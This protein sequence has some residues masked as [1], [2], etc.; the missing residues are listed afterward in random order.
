[1]GEIF[2]AIGFEIPDEDSY[3]VLAEYAELNGERSLVYRGGSALHGRCWK[4]GRGLEVWSILYGNGDDMYYA[5]CRPAF[6]SRYLRSIK[7]WE[8]T[9]YDEG[10]E[11]I[12]RGTLAG[13]D[14][15]FEL[16]NLT[17]VNP[18]VFQRQ[19]LDVALAGLAYSAQILKESS[20]AMHGWFGPADGVPPGAADD[21]CENDFII[22][23]RVRAFRDIQ[24]PVTGSDLVW[25]YLD[26]STI[27][28]EVLVNRRALKGRL[29]I[30]ALLNARLWLQGHV[31]DEAD[32]PACYEGVDTDWSPSD[33]WWTIRRPN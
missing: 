9:E 17:A 7:P 12:V 25:I 23:G 1:M 20:R 26:A 24:N 4:I 31:L 10:G 22:N 13:T 21:V 5:D 6:R 19:R 2:D 29:R 33:F 15:V 18:R 27:S 28:L 3:D 16:Q 14:I 11:A 30:G 8:L 32:K